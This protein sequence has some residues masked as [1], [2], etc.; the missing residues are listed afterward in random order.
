M[1]PR[2]ESREEQTICRSMRRPLT[3]VWGDVYNQ[4]GD[5]EANGGTLFA[6]CSIQSSL[7]K[8]S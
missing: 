7:F 2:F 4:G 8:V 6:G 5:I 1:T 3:L